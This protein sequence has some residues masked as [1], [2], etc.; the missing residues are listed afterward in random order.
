MPS[1][2]GRGLA[3]VSRQHLALWPW[4][5]VLRLGERWTFTFRR[6]ASGALLPST[7]T[8][9]H[10][11][12]AGPE[13]RAGTLGFLCGIQARDQTCLIMWGSQGPGSLQGGGCGLPGLGERLEK[14]L[15]I[16]WRTLLGPL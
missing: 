7:P 4:K 2:Q 16:P 14:P 10:L 6:V 5:A 12:L 9:T 11:P 1:A 8:L 13:P 3:C 15:Q